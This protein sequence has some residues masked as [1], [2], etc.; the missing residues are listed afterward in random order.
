MSAVHGH[1]PVNSP[2]R[3][4][5]SAGPS[6][7]SRFLCKTPVASENIISAQELWKQ[8]GPD[9]QTSRKL[10]L[11]PSAPTRTYMSLEQGWLLGERCQC[12]G[13]SLG[14]APPVPPCGVGQVLHIP[15]QD[16]SKCLCLVTE[17]FGPRTAP[18]QSPGKG[19]QPRGWNPPTPSSLLL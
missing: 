9:L 15:H 16:P 3:E 5:L 19:F 2:R 10:Q 11:L 12:S 6:R 14:L 7:L 13:S 1:L 18:V 8:G 17:Q 4:S